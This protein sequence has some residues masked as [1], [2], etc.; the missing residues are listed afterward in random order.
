MWRTHGARKMSG[1]F[2]A[3]VLALIL[4]V[5]ALLWPCALPAD[6]INMHYQEGLL[7]GFLTMRTEDGTAI[8]VG[9][10]TQIA[11]GDSVTSDLIFHFKDGS[12]YQETTVFSQRGKFQLLKYH[13]VQ[14]GPAF[15]HPTEIWLNG[16]TGQFTARYEE[17]S[18][19][20]KNITERIQVPTDVS[21]GML[22]TL[23]KN[24]QPNVEGITLS[25]VVAT[26]KPRVI[27]LAITY[28][29]EDPVL[30]AGSP[31]K[32]RHYLVKVELGGVA[33]VVAPL[34]KKQPPDSHVW[35]LSGEF[36]VFVRSVGALYEGG[37]IWTIEQTSPTWPDKSAE[38]NSAK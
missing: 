27:K 7:H 29:G 3:R 36:P 10:V 23:L 12:L 21:N 26:P 35:I 38:N 24:V 5:A 37:P 34:V 25:M 6:L 28:Q 16:P 9:D 19:K 1:K 11:R 8:A 32:A 15:N 31:R 4:A 22:T 2:H 20:E 17:D 14:K 18:G 13:L 30:I 33:G